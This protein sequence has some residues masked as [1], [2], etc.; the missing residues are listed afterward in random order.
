MNKEVK[1]TI[2]EINI[3]LT[4]HILDH[5]K[6]K[7]ILLDVSGG[8]DTRV[9]LSILL[10]YNIPFDV[11]TRRLSHGD[12][13]IASKIC[14]KFNLNQYKFYKRNT[15]DEEKEL[16]KKYDVHL[17]GTGYSEYMCMLHKLNKSINKINEI[18]DY[19]KTKKRNPKTYNPAFE[20]DVINLIHDIPLIYLMGGYIQKKLIKQNYPK[21]LKF[22]F[23]YYDFR[24]LLM[25]KLHMR[26]VD[27]LA[28]TWKTGTKRN[29]HE[30]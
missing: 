30:S 13:E 12:M 2:A 23:T 15:L 25:N 18:N 24:H 6:G 27:A 5:C 11:F 19:R 21:L 26:V 7:K 20:D 14:D 10:K 9:N 22:P 16:L 1:K 17:K 4:K 8:H 29:Y 28:N 3:Q